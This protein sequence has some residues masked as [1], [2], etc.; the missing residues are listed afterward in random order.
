MEA[1][2]EDGLREQSEAEAKNALNLYIRLQKSVIDMEAHVGG[3][4]FSMDELGVVESQELIL[5]SH[6]ERT[7]LLSYIRQLAGGVRESDLETWVSA[8]FYTVR[9][10]Y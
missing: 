10:R 4:R 9:K 2:E 8:G 6:I 3:R 7:G 5:Q 1:Y